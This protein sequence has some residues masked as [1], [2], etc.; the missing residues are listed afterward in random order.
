LNEESQ[1]D[2]ALGQRASAPSSMKN[3]L[4]QY[5]NKSSKF[6]PSNSKTKMQSHPDD[7]ASTPEE[8]PVFRPEI[9]RFFLLFK[10][11][12]RNAVMLEFDGDFVAGFSVVPC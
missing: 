6:G 8:S 5:R 4:P 7:H 3:W 10:Q 12:R 2:E 11:R 9:D 1:S